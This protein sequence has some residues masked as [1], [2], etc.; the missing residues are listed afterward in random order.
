M[1][2]ELHRF[3]G[4][5]GREPAPTGTSWSAGTAAARG[6]QAGL[7]RCFQAAGSYG[8]RARWEPAVVSGERRAQGRTLRS[9]LGGAAGLSGGGRL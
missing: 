9:I 4:V 8:R 2:S 1:N 3:V 5:E 7:A 6:V